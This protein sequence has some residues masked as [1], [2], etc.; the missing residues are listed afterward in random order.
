[1][2]S[3]LGVVSGMVD[4]LD[5]GG[6]ENFLWYCGLI[7]RVDLLDVD[8]SSVEKLFVCSDLDLDHVSLWFKY[9]A[10]DEHAFS[11]SLLFWKLIIAKLLS[12]PDI[13]HLGMKHVL[14]LRCFIDCIRMIVFVFFGK[15]YS[16]AVYVLRSLKVSSACSSGAILAM[17]EPSEIDH[18]FVI[19]FK[20]RD[21]TCGLIK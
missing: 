6:D 7:D 10:L 14:G 21:Y 15:P 13:E 16:L 11:S 3:S 5:D 17:V 18:L 2:K 8:R 20:C 19:S 1:M 12:F 4:E 9:L